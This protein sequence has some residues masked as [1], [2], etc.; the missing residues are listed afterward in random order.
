MAA[1]LS[2]PALRFAGMH[3]PWRTFREFSEW[4]LHWRRLPDGLLGITDHR[5]KV[6][7]LALGMSQAQRRCTIAHETEHI[8]RG[9]A[10]RLLVE[11]DEHWVRKDTARLMLGDIVAVGEALAWAVDLREA[12]DELWVDVDLLEDRLRHLHPAER[13]YLQRRLADD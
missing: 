1:G 5:L 12:A 10:P 13:G 4:T 8:K 2:D 6:V 9:P 11:K 3:H 7:T